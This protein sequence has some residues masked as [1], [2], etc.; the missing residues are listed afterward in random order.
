VLNLFILSVQL[1]AGHPVIREQGPDMNKKDIK[2]TINEPDH[3]EENT[4]EGWANIILK[5]DKEVFAK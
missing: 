1:R 2:K 5:K 4:L 3:S